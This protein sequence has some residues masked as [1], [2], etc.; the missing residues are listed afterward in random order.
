MY[1]MDERELMEMKF[2]D[3]RAMEPEVAT[4][5]F[6]ESWAKALMNYNEDLG[7]TKHY[8]FL[9]SF[10]SFDLAYLR[11]NARFKA[12]TKLRRIADKHGMRYDLYWQW[13][14]DAHLEL[15]FSK[16]FE[17][18][19][20]N[21]KIQAKI[22]DKK[23]AH[24]KTFVTWAKSDIFKPENYRNLELQN[25]YCWYLIREIKNRYHREHWQRRITIM[26]E[27]G[28]LPKD[29]FCNHYSVST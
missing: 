11:E 23:R 15:G 16:T 26:I 4:L 12:L 22:P 21:L 6:M 13:A 1:F 19:F 10:K 3:Y 18:V 24:E 2:F 5:V 8:A 29:F 28:R 14:F 9:K 17:N 25:D 7:K 27:N 20:L